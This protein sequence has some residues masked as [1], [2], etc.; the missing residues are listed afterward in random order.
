MV[1]LKILLLG[2]VLFSLL[3]NCNAAIVAFEC[4][5]MTKVSSTGTADTALNKM[6]GD[7]GR[8]S[9][10][11]QAKSLIDS[12]LTL[13]IGKGAAGVTYDAGVA[14]G[15]FDTE[16]A[17]AYDDVN[18]LQTKLETKNTTIEKYGGQPRAVTDADTHVGGDELLADSCN[19]QMGL[20]AY[21]LTQKVIATNTTSLAAKADTT[22][23]YTQA[24]IDT[25]AYVTLAS[26]GTKIGELTGANEML[27]KTA[28]ESAFQAKSTLFADVKAA[29]VDDE[30]FVTTATL[31]GLQV[32]P[33][34]AYAKATALEGNLT[35][36]GL[37]AELKKLPE[38]ESLE[39][40][41]KAKEDEKKEKEDKASKNTDDATNGGS[42][43]DDKCGGLQLIT[44]GSLF[45]LLVSVVWC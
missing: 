24:Q 29:T 33:L 18:S 19:Y 43:D 13:T 45:T 15:V 31:T 36:K 44:F 26:L 17:K 12:A 14:D 6:M 32:T 20:T 22:S 28:S 41:H 2:F 11:L 21:Y 10:A 42:P 39:K 30:K 35:I 5:G 1:N 34:K 9:A 3:L 38:W 16:V 8:A 25:A 4:N 23:I 40:T 37:L 7:L 27:T